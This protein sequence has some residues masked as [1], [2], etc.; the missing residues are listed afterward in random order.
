MKLT[1]GGR[2]ERTEVRSEGGGP[3]P[4]GAVDPRFDPAQTRS[5]SGNSGALGAVYSFTPGLALAV[6]GAYTERAPTYY[7]LFANGPHAATGSFELG[8]T[9]FVKEKSKA[10]DI[11]LRLKSGKHSGSI[12]VFE[13]RFN[14]FITLFNTGNTRGADGE[15]NPPNAGD[16]TSLNTGEE[17]LPELD[18]RAVPARFRG[19]EGEGRFRVFEGGGNLDLLVNASHVRA[20]DRST[21][22]PLP[23]IAPWRYGV[24]LDY[25]QDRLGARVDA[26]VYA[27]QDRVAAGELPTDGYTMLNAALTYRLPAAGMRLEAFVR[28]VN[29]LNEEARNHVSILKDIAPQGRRSGQIGVRGQF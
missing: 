8:N 21:G 24:G 19:V 16:G 14:N 3:V 20:N 6:N 9:A 29:L 22:Q 4:F 2:H 17:I 18:Y 7:E 5:F 27:D 23:R 1:F 26:T 15:L 28:G 25:R 11:S 10:V 12:G 13:N